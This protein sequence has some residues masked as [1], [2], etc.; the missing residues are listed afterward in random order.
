MVLNDQR[1]EWWRHAVTYQ[2][3]PRSFADANGDGV[4]DLAGITARLPHL[5]D[6]GVDAIWLSP[7]YTSP[8]PDHGYDVADYRDVDPLFGRLADAD[9]LLA[10]AHDARPEGDRRPGPQ[11]HLPPST[12]GSRPRWPRRRAVPS[13]RATSSATAGPT[14]AAQQLAAR[15]S[16]A[17]R[18]PSCPTASG[19]STSSTPP[20]PT[21]TGATPRS[22]TC[23]STCCAS[24]WTAASTASAS[25]SRTACSRRRACA[26]RQ[27]GRARCRAAAPPRRRTD[28]RAH[29]RDEPMW[30]QP[31]VHDVYRAGTTCSRSTTA[32]GCSSPRPGPR[33]PESMALY[34]RPDEMSQAFNFAWLLAGWS[35]DRVRRRHHRHPRRHRL[36]RALAHVGAQQPRRRAARQPV[37]RRRARP[38][39]G[40]RGHADDA[41]AAGVVVPL[42]GR[43]ARP[44]AGRRRSEH[45]QDPSWFR[46]GEPGRDG[47]RVPIPWSGTSRAV[48]LRARRRSAL[49]AAA[50]DVGATSPSRPRP[51]SRTRR[52]SFYRS[53]LSARRTFAATAGD[54]VKILERTGDVLAFT[55]GP[56]T[57]V[58][59]CGTAPV[60]AARRRD[61]DGERAGRRRTPC[62]HG[63]VAGL[64]GGPGA[65]YPVHRVLRTFLGVATPRNVEDSLRGPAGRQASRA[66]L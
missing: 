58:L 10:H 7:F 4:G 41:G 39:T 53:A 57:V 34:V 64:S 17:P 24:G 51:A 47:C 33:P 14:A 27:V 29:L 11:P 43:G 19:T 22:A 6:L 31:E 28:G 52:S 36:G 45:R 21:S 60:R 56:V 42:P 13:E 12:P 18:G 5:R 61:P 30:D 37:R 40:P 2:I 38:G 20:S 8:Q 55:R 35:A 62:G 16:V 3:Y 46:T 49:A 32:T 50:R 1:N 15:S 54:K 48:R 9:A 23:S 44:R 25:M 63:G 66:W 26:T 65:G 59:N